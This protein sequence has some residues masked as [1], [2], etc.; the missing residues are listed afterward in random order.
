[1][2]ELYILNAYFKFTYAI[3]LIVLETG[4]KLNHLDSAGIHSS[5][6]FYNGKAVLEMHSIADSTIIGI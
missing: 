4:S 1:M 3:H 5:H 6:S 2:I